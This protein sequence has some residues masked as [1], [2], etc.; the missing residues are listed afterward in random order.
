MCISPLI[1][2]YDPSFTLT[3]H[4][5]IPQMH[6]LHSI[7]RCNNITCVCVCLAILSALRNLQEKIRTLEKERGRAVQSIYTPDRTA[8]HKVTQPQRHKDTHSHAD[9]AKHTDKHKHTDTHTHA[10]IHTHT[11]THSQLGTH[12]KRVGERETSDKSACNQGEE[13][14]L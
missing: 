6:S 12:T 11:G 1:L 13:G 8:T 2:P 10:D 9:I 14:V 5:S 4:H 3:P 7:E